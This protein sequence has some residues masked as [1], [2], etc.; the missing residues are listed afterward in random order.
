M[1]QRK[2]IHNLAIIAL[3]FVFFQ[4]ATAEKIIDFNAN[5][6]S[7]PINLLTSFNLDTT[8]PSIDAS[9]SDAYTGPAI[10]SSFNETAGGKSFWS[11][12]TPNN[13]GLKLRWNPNMGITGDFSSA[14]FLFKKSEFLNGF[15]QVTVKMDAGN[16]SILLKTGYLNLGSVQNGS[17]IERATIRIVLK[18]DFGYFI[19]SP[20]IAE[21]SQSLSIKV[22]E[23]IFFTYDPFKSRS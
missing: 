9:L 15:N 6:I 10:Y 8:T 21:S 18:N 14:L 19:S 22:T 5:S 1:H 20:I 16:D 7:S 11:A 17:P 12:H 3:I 2:L 13:S 4:C 23:L